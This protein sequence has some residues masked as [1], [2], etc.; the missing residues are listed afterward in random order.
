MTTAQG[1]A[2]CTLIDGTTQDYDSVLILSLVEEDGDIKIL[3]LKDF[4]D[5]QKRSAFYAGIAK[6]V[7]KGAPAS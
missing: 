7:A 2:R 4:T 1:T 5:P 6:V 3:E